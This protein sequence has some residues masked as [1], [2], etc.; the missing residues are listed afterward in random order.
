MNQPF[1]FTNLITLCVHYWAGNDSIADVLSY[2]EY[3]PNELYR[4][5]RD[6]AEQAV[7][8]NRITVAQR[9]LMLGAFSESLRS[10]T[11]FER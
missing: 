2:V 6:T 7:R 5:F 8:E 1:M 11:Y 9:Q 10:Y 3:Q 4:K